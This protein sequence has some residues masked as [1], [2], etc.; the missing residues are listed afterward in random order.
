MVADEVASVEARAGAAPWRGRAGPL[1]L[2]TRYAI[3]VAG[4]F[5]FALGLVL[6]LKAALGLGPWDVF[7]WGLKRHTGLTFGQANI[8]VS[9]VVLLVAW[10]LGQ[11]PRVGTV[12]NMLLV[13]TFVDLIVRSGVIPSVEHH[14]W[15]LRLAVDLAGVAVVG[16]GTAFYIKGDLGAGP[17]DGL[18]LVLTRRS[19][20]PIALVRGSIELSVLVVGFFLGGTAG[21]GTLVFALGIGPAVAGAF[22]LFRINT[23]AKR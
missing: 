12:L 17:R 7:H 23:Q 21:P 13:G 20:R 8:I 10:A 9:L 19:G 6:T 18:M 22:K 11:R 15:P 4:L 5:C 3:L 14:A 1:R 16:L 2:A